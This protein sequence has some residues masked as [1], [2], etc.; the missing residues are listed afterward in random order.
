MGAPEDRIEVTGNLKYDAKPPDV[1][2]FAVWLD[3]QIRRQER[4][5]VL[6][7]GSVVAE[8]EEAVVAAYDI[9]QRRWRHALL[10]LAPRKPD[11]FDD[12]AEIAAAGGWTVI[13]RSRL[14]MSSTLD[15]N[16]DVL[17]L[18]SIGELAGLYSLADA[19]FVGGSL[20]PSGGHNILEPAW[21]SKP[22]VFGPSMENFSEMAAQFLAARAGIQVTSGPQLGKVWVQLIE[23]VPV[24]E[25]M[26][27]AAHEISKRNRG[28]TKRSI[29]RITAL[30]RK[31]ENHT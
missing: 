18:D 6:V 29:D 12:T 13:R 5:P 8:E 21:F 30:L 2:P 16:A 20:V 25:R 23:D 14:D 7:A 11:R 10:I 26:G 17:L 3:S 22:P 4:W 31:N 24:R 19:V 9:V 28:A 27:K 1:T 15:E